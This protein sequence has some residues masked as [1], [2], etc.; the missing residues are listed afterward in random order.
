MPV[1]GLSTL[2]FSCEATTKSDMN[3]TFLSLD[4]VLM[5]KM[6]LY[7]LG[8]SSLIL[9]QQALEKWDGYFLTPSN[10]V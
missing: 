6:N 10:Q 5:K 1:L 8:G 2:T 4:L 7:C 3:V 9:P